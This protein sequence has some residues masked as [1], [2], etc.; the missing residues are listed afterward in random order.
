MLPLATPSPFP[1][2]PQVPPLHQH[3]HDSAQRIHPPRTSRRPPS[4]L[5][6]APNDHLLNHLLPV[7]ASPTPTHLK[8]PSSPSS[9]PHPELFRLRQ[10]LHH[11]TTN[12]RCPG[13]N[14]NSVTP[15][16]LRSGQSYALQRARGSLVSDRTAPRQFGLT[17]WMVAL[18]SVSLAT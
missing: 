1:P 14:V 3:P 6:T 13:Y 5:P 7:T 8:D 2:I 12:T 11:R 16:R 17:S 15:P 4:T 9:R 10:S 18:T